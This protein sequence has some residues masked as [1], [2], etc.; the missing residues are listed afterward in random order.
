MSR[1]P[2]VRARIHLQAAI[3]VMASV[4]NGLDVQEA[5]GVTGVC[6][7]QEPHQRIFFSAEISMVVAGSAFD[8]GN[9]NKI[10]MRVACLTG[11][12]RGCGLLE[13]CQS[14][15]IKTGEVR[16]CNDL[17]EWY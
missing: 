1:H 4:V 17:E 6:R 16:G 3:F 7:R 2:G 15:G 12:M 8:L 9:C 14:P 13:F 10:C 5:E 11:A